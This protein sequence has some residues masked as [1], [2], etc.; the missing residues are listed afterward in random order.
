MTLQFL[1]FA[2]AGLVGSMVNA[3]A[4]GAKLFVFPMLLASG[5]PPLVANATGTAGI[6]PGQLSA[7][8]AFRREL[9]GDFA[10]LLRRMVPAFFGAFLGALL[11]INSSE[12]AF[13]A[14]IPFL[15]AIAVTAIALGPRITRLVRRI[16][17]PGRIKTT[18]AVLLFGCGV[19]GGYFGAGLGF[20]LLATL[21]LSGEFEFREANAQKN[22]FA[23]CLNAV[24]IVPLT[25]S[26]LIDWFAAAGI[27]IGGLAGG[28]LGGSLT[29]LLPETIT[30]IAVATV[31]IVLT[32]SFLL[33]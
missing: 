31:G 23:F 15:L 19:Y 4:G 25:L 1:L 33:R 9:A 27:V 24:A 17:P 8:T 30:R 3:L 32:A 13:L 6:W 11:L 26:G 10:G 2:A 29:R 18:T 16:V 12:T 20:L 28:Y 14:V 22:L 7:A 21:S 5:L